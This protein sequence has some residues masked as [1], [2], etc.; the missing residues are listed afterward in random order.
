MLKFHL[1]NRGIRNVEDKL[2]IY[3]MISVLYVH[4]QSNIPRSDFQ[5]NAHEMYIFIRMVS[6]NQD[7]KAF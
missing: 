2:C 5:Y 1:Q 6:R 4:G 3:I 7:C